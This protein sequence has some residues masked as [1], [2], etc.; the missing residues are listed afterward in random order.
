MVMH[1]LHAISGNLRIVSEL[2]ASAEQSTCRNAHQRLDDSLV[3]LV[4]VG[5]KFG[6]S[7]DNLQGERGHQWTVKK[8]DANSVVKKVVQNLWVQKLEERESHC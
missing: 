6:V 1:P 4:A 8:R 7:F 3:Q 5:F 2:F